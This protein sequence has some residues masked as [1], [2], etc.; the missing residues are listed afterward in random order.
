M[1]WSEELA[2]LLNIYMVF[3][4]IVVV[5]FRGAHLKI[6]VLERIV[7]SRPV[8][9]ALRTLHLA[10]ALVFLL[11]LSYGAWKLTASSWGYRLS[12]MAWANRGMFYLGPLI[13]C[14]LSSVVLAF[15]LVRSLGGTADEEVAG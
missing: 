6:D 7:T 12:T 2:R 11:C 10:L 15:Q 3:F 5:T 14:S 8:L 1:M 9:R 13:G 4:G